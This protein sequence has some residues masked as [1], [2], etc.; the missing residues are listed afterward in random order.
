MWKNVGLFRDR[1]GLA[2]ALST[3][4]PAWQSIDALL[5]EQACSDQEMWRL[6]SLLTVGMLITR[7][8]L[9]REE[10]RGAH[11]RADYPQRDDIHWKRRVSEALNGR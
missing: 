1:P 9:R 3:L 11:Y 5:S 2:E 10:S 8:A 6:A 4:E 7:A